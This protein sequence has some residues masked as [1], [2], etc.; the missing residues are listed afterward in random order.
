MSDLEEV[1]EKVVETVILAPV[2]IVVGTVSGIG[3]AFK[4]LT[5]WI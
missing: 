5:D 3:S 2:A 1:T 4:K